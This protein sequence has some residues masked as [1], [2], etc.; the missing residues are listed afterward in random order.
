METKKV[1]MFKANKA[2]NRFNEN[3]VV[4]IRFNHANHLE[5]CFK[6][7]GNGRYVTGYVDNLAPEVGEIKSI[8]VDESFANRIGPQN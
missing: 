8:D 7:R 4:W 5:V 2:T 1:E 3:Q 6:W